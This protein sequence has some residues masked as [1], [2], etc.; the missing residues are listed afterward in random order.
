MTFI[1]VGWQG[2]NNE[3]QEWL[4]VN[5]WCISIDE[6]GEWKRVKKTKPTCRE[7]ADSVVVLELPSIPTLPEPEPEPEPEPV[8]DS[9][10]LNLCDE[11]NCKTEGGGFWYGDVCNAEDEVVAEPEP[12]PE[13][14]PEPEFNT[15]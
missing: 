14:E 7:S 9:A 15:E 5:G 1:N 12:I 3:N 6:A 2:G 13:S 10:N 11:S 8:C 4:E